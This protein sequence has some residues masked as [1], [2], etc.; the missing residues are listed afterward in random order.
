MYDNFVYDVLEDRQGHLWFATEKGVARYDGEQFT[1]FTTNE[2]LTR[3]WVVSMLEDRAG[4]LWFG[5]MGG[6]VSRYDGFAFQHLSVQDGLASNLIQ[7]LI[8]T[9]DGDVW[10]ATEGG[11]TRDLTIGRAVERVRS[12]ALSMRQRDDMVKMVAVMWQELKDLGVDVVSCQVAFLDEAADRIVDY[13]AVENPRKQGIS[14]TSP[15]MVEVNE[16]I[17]VMQLETTASERPDDYIAQ[18]RR[19]EPWSMEGNW[20]SIEETHRFTDRLGMDQSIWTDGQISCTVVPFA[21]G[22]VALNTPVFSEENV[23]IVQAF[24]EALSLGYIRYL[25]F[26]WLEEARLAADAANQAKSAFLANMS[27]ELRTPLNSVIAMSDILLEKYFGPLTEDQEGYVTDVRDSGHHLLELINEILD[28]S[29]IEAGYSP[30]ELGEV[31]L[32]GLLE[33]SLTVV[34]ERAQ[35]HGIELS[36]ELTEDLP[37]VVADERKVRQV[38][39]NLLSNAVKFTPDGGRVGIAAERE[40]E[41]G[42]RVCVWDTGIGITAEDHE[43]VFRV[44]EQAESA[45]DKQYEGAGL[46]LALVERFV[47]QHGGRV[48]LESAPGEGSRFFFT[49]PLEAA[50]ARVSESEE[51]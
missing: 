51:S 9:R 25:D 36:C 21:Y 39:F 33:N 26:Q 38:V 32:G 28:L 45:P 11:L 20:D 8:Q 24:T 1:T 7:D 35:N 14:W 46:G 5:T 37:G 23:P 34:R 42:V 41:E 3:D 16:D 44:F 43:K 30:L 10:I 12:E 18:W 13:V 22:S 48:W 4:H 49:L 27:H 31:D 17:A 19:G 15:K 40:G 6:G 29:K 47:E 2:G 50:D